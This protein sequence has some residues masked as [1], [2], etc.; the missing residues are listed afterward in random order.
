M[1][2]MF[3]DKEDSMMRL[4]AAVALVGVVLILSP[5]PAAA[6]AK[7]GDSEILVS[8][9]VSSFYSPGFTNTTGT[10]F[11]NYGYFLTP[12][13][14]VG[15]GPNL[16]VSSGGGD[17]SVSVGFNLFGRYYFPVMSP[18]LKPYVGGEYA[19]RD[20]FPGEFESFSDQQYLNALGGLK[21]YLNERTALDFKLSYGFN[22][23]HAGDLQL[24]N[25]TVGLTYLF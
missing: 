5:A 24:F 4:A 11:G 8:A 22:P 17:T 3:Q 9:N 18:K 21:D 19:I 7:E 12:K 10:I 1:N 6:Q 14:E 25:F 2:R 20:L 16:G 23:A 15:L 13:V